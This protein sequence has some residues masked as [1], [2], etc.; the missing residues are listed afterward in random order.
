ML[1]L[2]V[3]NMV[4]L[5]MPIPQPPVG[6]KPYSNAVQKFSSTICASSSPAAL[7]FACCSNRCRCTTGS[8]N[9]VYALHTSFFMTNNSK[10]SVRPGMERCHF[11]RG[12]MIW[13]C[14]V[15][16][17]GLMHFSSMYS[18]HSLSRRRAVVRGGGHSMLFAER[19]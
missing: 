6:G 13:G 8:F 2:S 12:L 3:K 18:P 19:K 9:S 17:V 10:R 14:S 16:K 4:N 15:M 7:S 1:L 11:A 5:S